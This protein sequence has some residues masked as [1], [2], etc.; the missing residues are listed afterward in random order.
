MEC[1]TLWHNYLIREPS[2]LQTFGTIFGIRK[3]FSIKIHPCESGYNTATSAMLR[4]KNGA[5]I[6]REKW[7]CGEFLRTF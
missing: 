5:L 4:I 2:P 3:L 1:D 7:S 6:L